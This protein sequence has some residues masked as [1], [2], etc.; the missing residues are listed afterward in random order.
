M[1]G[2]TEN[3]GLANGVVADDLIEPQHH[4]R[5]ADTLDR[6]LGSFLKRMMADGAYSGWGLTMAGT[7]TPGEGLVGGCWCETAAPAA[8]ES[9]TAGATNY[10]F[11]GV[12]D[13]SAPA[14]GVRFSGALSQ[15]KPPGA[16]LLGS[17]T[18]NAGG[19]VTAVDED[20]AGVDRNC[21]RLEVGRA[22]GNGVAEAVPGGHQVRVEVGHEVVFLVPGALEV[23]VSSGGFDWE[24]RDAHEAGG[25]AIVATNTGGPPANFVYAWERRGLIA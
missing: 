17:M 4:N 6:V 20:V 8:V 5:M 18:V 3:Y 19:Q 24:V 14:G 1:A 7:V 21:L 9:L 2:T 10:V 16:V 22:T 15:T 11:G 23:T 25:F 13:D 12:A